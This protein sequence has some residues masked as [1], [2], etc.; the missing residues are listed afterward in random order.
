MAVL[1]RMFLGLLAVAGWLLLA[2]AAILWFG[3]ESGL[4]ARFVRDAA[5]A[6]LGA[7]GDDL[8]LE[9]VRF[10]W[11][12]RAI[13]IDRVLLGPGGE[14]ANLRDV[15]IELAG[16]EDQGSPVRRI[17][18]VSGRVR[19]SPALTNG[20]QRYTK[21]IAGA[22]KRVSGPTSLPTV[23]VESLDLEV[24]SRRW[25]VLPIGR[26]DV[27]ARANARGAPEI[28]GRLVPALSARVG[29]PGEIYVSG[30]MSDE[31]TLSLRANATRMPLGVDGL[32]QDED[33]D[34]LRAFEPSGL[35]ELQVDA[36]IPLA[37]GEPRAE[38]RLAL[39]RGAARM[40]AGKQRFE[41]VR[42]DIEAAWKPKD[43]TEWRDLETW[44]ALARATGTWNGTAFDAT[45][46]LGDEAG[47]E[48]E[49]EFWA[50]LP[51]LALEPA[52]LATLDAGPLA[53]R[54]WDG[55]DPRGSTEVWV[56]AHVPRDRGARTLAEAASVFALARPSG[57]AALTYLGMSKDA[58]GVFDEGFPLPLEKVSGEI[59][60]VLDPERQHRWSIALLDL[61]GS[62]GEGSIRAHGVVESPPRDVDPR[63]PTAEYAEMDLDIAT[64]RLPIDQR[65][66][67][68]LEGLAGP[69]PPASTWKP[70]Q[71]EG[72]QIGVVLRLY[73]EARLSWLATDLEVALQDV[74]LAWE[75]LPVPFQR[76]S[77]TLR[78]RSDGITES[79]LGLRLE[80]SLRTA[81]KARVALRSRTIGG[82]Q[83]HAHAPLD[84]VSV[85]AIDVERV[86]LTGD[87]RRIL[88]DHV[89]GIGDGLEELSPRG[90]ADIRYER[91]RWDPA[92][93]LD[94]RAEATPL[95]P[96]Q[97]VPKRFPMTAS[98]VR[99]RA[100]YTA[101]EGAG[102]S[103][104][105]VRIAPLIASLSDGSSVSIRARLPDGAVT[106]LA[107]GVDPANKALLGAVAGLVGP[108]DTAGG[109]AGGRALFDSSALSFSGRLDLAS[110][111][112]L[113][114]K[115]KEGVARPGSA[116]P[117][118]APGAKA[119]TPGGDGDWRFFLRGSKL[120]TT[121]GFQ[122][123]DLRGELE[124]HQSVL[125]GSGLEARLAETP[126][127]LADVRFAPS[128]DDWKLETGF[129]ARD[130][131]LDRA[132]L[133]GFF[134]T[135]TLNALLD[136]FAWKGRFDFTAGRLAITIPPRGDTRLE[137]AGE[138]EPHAMS[139][140]MGLPLEI[141]TAT[142]H[143]DKLVREDGKVRALAT[144]D[145]LSGRLASR[146]LKEARMVLTYVEPALSIETLAG[147]LEGGSLRP[148]GTGA[149][150]AG[151]PFWIA[152][153]KPFPFQV[154]LDLRDVDVAGLL[155]GLFP[156][157][158]ATRGKV[159]A[160]LRLA[161]DL[162]HLLGIQ[163][164][165]S[166]RLRQSRLWS[167]PVFRALF[168]QLGLDDTATFDS[169]YTNVKIRDGVIE[170]DDILLRS[171]LLQ[172]VGSG[173]LDLDGR[174]SHDL[175]VRYELV[176]NLGPLTRMIYWIQNG[177]LSV[178]IRGDM[179][180]PI[181]VIQNP[182]RRLFGSGRDYRA[183]PTPGYAP[184]PPRF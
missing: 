92:R 142:L 16:A 28:F 61:V 72:G 65:I 71:P 135:V 103:E 126:V 88:V 143:L 19:F 17:E 152:L 147:D 56:G 111:I 172:L 117:D 100:L 149:E 180:R 91:V 120:A 36:R 59:A 51:D 69:L 64:D 66:R 131:P 162:E 174:L 130:V 87:D 63:L 150:R 114:K 159:D 123:D 98:D 5:A 25:G 34:F 101:R 93:P 74:S 20:L 127:A 53:K 30:T 122:L 32:P 176:D 11:F 79:A 171:P 161:G 173:T 96:A 154:A 26:L 23:Q 49:V 148:L 84:E 155:R 47:T 128:G 43:L 35:L 146:E 119:A 2:V 121:T 170:M 106:I 178:S 42:L 168:G 153:Q 12:D 33:L 86:A 50:R 181:V 55:L 83:A 118:D 4:V 89:P 82:A 85:A 57:A 75:D 14:M 182:L 137:L 112:P 115:P 124:L 60:F 10:R 136:D 140:R 7:L 167:V 40:Q 133:G 158:I 48:H 94:V 110:E 62:A 169:M 138:F 97:I 21:H 165:G 151:T 125:F 177:L 95:A 102:V 109:T 183:L 24:V 145:G 44:H 105:E 39:Q 6:E 67:T 163:G 46:L 38:L 129:D 76:A 68:A 160:E 141:E 54:I 104:S 27:L 3:E 164:T 166:V 139:L 18:V 134:D 1:A 41:S 144:I 52:L 77:G 175:E 116:M 132:H 70:F 58:R 108:R 184:L 31:N 22:E 99:G 37:G 45:A 13:E 156:S 179:G 29:E 9:G 8:K 15:R 78:F 113:A 81:Q 90:F 73:R 157:G 107:A 80:G